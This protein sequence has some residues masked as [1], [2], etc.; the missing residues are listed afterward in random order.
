MVKNATVASMVVGIAVVALVV[1][2]AVVAAVDVAV[3]VGSP[4]GVEQGGRDTN[5]GKREGSAR[6]ETGGDREEA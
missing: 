3:D 1:V 5:A 4:R 6:S 2:A